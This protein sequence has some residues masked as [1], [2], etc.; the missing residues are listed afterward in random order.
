MSEFKDVSERGI[1]KRGCAC[2]GYLIDFSAEP[3]WDSSICLI[4]GWQQ[5]VSQEMEPTYRG[6]PNRV[7]LLTARRNYFKVGASLVR[8]LLRR[9]RRPPLPDEIP[10]GGNPYEHIYQQIEPHFS[11]PCCFYKTF[12]LEPKDTL[13]ACSVCLWTDEMPLSDISEDS[14]EWMPAL[15][16]VSLE[17]A[18]RNFAQWGVFQE[19][20]LPFARPPRPE[21]MHG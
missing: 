20:Y 19:K 5:N 14:P 16:E 17:Q 1:L 15:N 12:E 6:G 4:C 18:Q 9:L 11:C 3:K 2:C 21:E 7:D 10:S 8:R 13:M